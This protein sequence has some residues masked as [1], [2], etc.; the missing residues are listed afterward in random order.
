MASA[1]N[2][3]SVSADPSG[4]WASRI[5]PP[6]SRRP[7]PA[8]RADPALG[9]PWPGVTCAATPTRSDNSPGPGPVARPGRWSRSWHSSRTTS[10]GT[11]SAGARMRLGDYADGAWMFIATCG[12]R[13]RQAHVDP[14]EVLAHPSTHTPHAR[15]RTCDPPAL[16]GLPP[17]RY[18]AARWSNVNSPSWPRPR[19][20]AT[21]SP[22][23]AWPRRRSSIAYSPDTPGHPTDRQCS[24]WRLAD[25]SVPDEAMPPPFWTRSPTRDHCR[26]RTASLH[27]GRPVTLGGRSGRPPGSLRRPPNPDRASSSRHS[28]CE[29]S[30]AIKCP[31]KP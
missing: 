11:T 13:G 26:G 25:R 2:A 24:R 23:A 19:P 28:S 9:A 6:R 10:R 12:T 8:R 3:S 20:S 29:N 22:T 1:T 17:P 5:R 14:A 31:R 21:Q 4:I 15:G 30:L 27:W 7:R 18:H 16:S